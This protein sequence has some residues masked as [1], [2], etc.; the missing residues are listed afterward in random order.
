MI[1]INKYKI[2]LQ[3]FF[4]LGAYI[5]VYLRPFFPDY[6]DGKLKKKLE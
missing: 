4:P 3:V 5:A 2:N 6:V 1:N